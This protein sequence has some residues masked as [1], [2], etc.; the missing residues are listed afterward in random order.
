MTCLMQRGGT[1]GER[2]EGPEVGQGG[3]TSTKPFSERKEGWGGREIFNS[4][5]RARESEA[6][7]WEDR[8]SSM[9]H[10]AEKETETRRWSGST[11]AE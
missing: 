11:G 9:T 8:K 5:K 3:S 6:E 1:S 2:V 4:M 7:L 10:G